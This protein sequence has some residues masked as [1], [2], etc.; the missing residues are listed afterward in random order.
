MDHQLDNGKRQAYKNKT[1]KNWHGQRKHPII[2]MTKVKKTSYL[3]FLG[4]K[5]YM[6]EWRRGL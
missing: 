1:K 2:K 3:A 4:V 5:G 6:V